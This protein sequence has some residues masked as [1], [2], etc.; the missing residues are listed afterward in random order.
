MDIDVIKIT[1]PS[2][3]T[4][5]SCLAIKFILH[6]KK[7]QMH[8][9][10]VLISISNPCLIVYNSYICV[11]IGSRHFNGTHAKITVDTL[12]DVLYQ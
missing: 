3:T 8:V 5:Y 7:C 12:E 2:L 4:Q 1:L 11:L 9:P 6:N 10:T